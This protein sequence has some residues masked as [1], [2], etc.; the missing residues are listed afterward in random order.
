MRKLGR[1]Q[2]TVSSKRQTELLSF[3]TEP[4]AQLAGQR[5]LCA[6]KRHPPFCSK[7]LAFAD[8]IGFPG[9]SKVARAPPTCQSPKNPS[10]SSLDHALHCVC[11][12]VCP[13]TLGSALAVFSPEATQPRTAAVFRESVCHS[14]LWCGPCKPFTQLIALDLIGRT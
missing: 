4:L 10:T 3:K 14:A 5:S 11:V 7:Q 2:R 13:R 12:R 6:A 1:R 8:C 9:A